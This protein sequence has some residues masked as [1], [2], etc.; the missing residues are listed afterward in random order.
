MKTIK[1]TL[2]FGQAIK[3]TMFI[4]PQ[5]KADRMRKTLLT[6]LL[7]L[8]LSGIITFSSRAADAGMVTLRGHVPAVVSQLQAKGN[9]PA[10][11]NLDLAIGLPLRN[12]EAL[13]NLLQQIYD[14]ASPNY[15]HYLTT[16]QFTEQFGP[17]MQ[18]YQMVINFA[19][20]NGLVVTGTYSNRVVLDVRGKVSD[21]ENTFHVTLHTYQHPTENR[22]FFAPDAEPSIPAG[23]PVIGICGLNNYVIPRPAFHKVPVSS[24]SP[25]IQPSVGSGPITGTYMGYDFR[26]AYVPGTVLT[27]VRQT[28]A[29]FELDGYYANDILTYEEQAGL[30][31]IPLQNVLVDGYNGSIGANNVEVALDIEMAIAMAP[32]LSK[33][34]IYEGLN[35]GDEAIITDM[36]NRIAADN[37]ARQISSS[38]L[39]PDTTTWD[40][41][42]L[43]YAAQGQSFFQASGDN[44]AF[45]WN[46]NFYQQQTD[47]PYITL[48]GGTTL[49]TSGPNGRRTA[50]TVWNWGS[51]GA[52][53]WAEGSGGGISPTYSI[54]SWQTNINMT[55]NKGSTTARN[56]PDVA[57]TADN[58]YVVADNGQE[59]DVGGTSAAA[60][61]WAGFTALVNQQAANN[62]LPSVGF[63]NPAVYAIA[64]S[65]NYSNCFNDI[66]TGN[67]SSS[68]SPTLFF[69]TPGYDLCTGLGSPKG[70]NLINALTL[71]ANTNTITHLSAPL[72]P[73]GSALAALNGG[74]P[75]GTWELFV[76]DDAKFNSG[77]ISNGWILTLTT[78][79]IVGSAADLALSM[80]ASAS[81][82]L[83]GENLTYTIGVTN[84]GPSASTNIVVSDTLPAGVTVVSTA[85]TQGSVSRGGFN[86]NNLNWN[87]GSLSTSAGAQLTLTVQPG[88]V[89]PILN[90]AISKPATPDP[91]PADDYAS[92]QVTVGV[93]TPPELTGNFVG[94]NGTFQFT[95]SGGD[96][97]NEIIEASTNLVNWTPVY[98]NVSPF[99][100]T[101]SYAPNYP[102]RF[103]RA[104][105][106]P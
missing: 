103:Y 40:Q 56:I 71:V 94:A 64:N 3:D 20:V 2:I 89:G 51:G 8:A 72:P 18:D 91:N 15:H 9:L 4:A 97:Q 62:G 17:T 26:N 68:N 74:N 99:T 29:L 50:E 102:V 88:N 53:G 45:N 41:I 98:T 104:R 24:L 58:I 63:I 7:G 19:K 92:V 95:L 32:G 69:A 28:V 39:L 25:K 11:T 105:T 93:P 10:D 54:P 38:W 36:L 84:Y 86:L 85:A 49:S 106:S 59:E 83:V 35:D 61:L 82:I 80:T 31:N 33:V 37:S 44:D 16:E 52:S 34:I 75:N 100:F 66:T 81:N 76:Q 5:I 48:V 96:G 87:V 42:Y 14:P 90:Y 70:T 13:T 1:E 60:P 23:L 73:Y 101:D 57:L 27:G 65:T 6:I 22:T 55:A 43:E 46:L 47:D 30:T 78:A 21:I 79:N 77:S 67:N 12:T